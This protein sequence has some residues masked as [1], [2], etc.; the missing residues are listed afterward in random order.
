MDVVSIVIP[1][2]NRPQPL[3][4]AVESALAQARPADLELEILV[5]DN[6]ADGNAR[7]VVEAFPAIS[8]LPVR[9]V[10]APA[11][12][13]ANARNAG[14]SAATGRWIAFLDDDQEAS[15]GWLAAHVATART[16]GADAVFGPAEA[17]AEDGGAMG[18]FGPYFSRAIDRPDAADITDLSAYLGT[19]NSMFDRIRC[20][21]DDPPFDTSLNEFG[22]EDSLL[23]KRLVIAGRRFAWSA[24]GGV[25]E[26]VPPRRL[27]WAYV[28]KRK[29]LS[30]QI[31]SFVPHMLKP[32]RWG[33]IALWMAVGAAQAVAAGAMAAALAPIDR[34]RSAKALATA[35]GGLGKILWMPRFRSAMYGSGLVS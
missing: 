32:T 9:Y 19:N 35:F 29:F 1:T 21:S 28:R 30:G 8:G 11:P 14:V 18:P 10:A 24:D 12:G 2:L 31:R 6:S 4:R 3:R 22:G 26:W 15:P 23:L 16:T 13:V 7:A 34:T 5:V 27:N 33:T 20:L 25:V 17:R